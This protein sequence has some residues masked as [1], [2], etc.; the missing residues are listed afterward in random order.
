M[1]ATPGPVPT[2]PRPLDAADT[3]SGLRVWKF[4]GTSVGDL[5]RIRKVAARIARQ[6][7]QGDRVVV[8]V[9]AMGRT[10]DRL[11]G[12]ARELTPRPDRREL[13]ALMA[14]GEQQATALLCLALQALHVPARSFTGAQAGFRTSDLHG[15]ASI[16]EVDPT[17]LRA[18]LS[19]VRVVAV[20]GFQGLNSLGDTATLGRGGS[21]TTAVALAAALG[22]AECE[23][24][25]DT[26]GVYTTDPHLVPSATRLPEVDYDEMLELAQLGAKVLHPRSVWYARRYGVRV[27]VRSSFSF[28]PGTIVRRLDRSEDRM[29]T[30]SPVTGVALDRNH[31]RIDLVGLPDTPGVAARLFR[32]LGNAHVSVDMIIQGVPGEGASRQQMAFTVA[33]DLVPDALDAVAP[34][35]AE[36]GGHADASGDVAKLSIVGVAV[37]ST[38]GVAGTMFDAVASVGANIEM[39]ATSEVRVSVVIPAE[40][41]EDALKAVHRAFGLEAA[42]S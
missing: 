6:V 31:A 36:I 17:R 20:A 13:D 14:T 24:F 27:H 41:A 26:D 37:G 22:A 39:I 30:D 4:G 16:L 33:E 3:A 32:A 38:P 10:T 21:D 23:I 8:T 5:D 28:A 2:S 29:I 7:E 42:P 12:M 34:I 11:V 18:A 19:T 15:E 35:L 9:S 25:T 1:D 40:H